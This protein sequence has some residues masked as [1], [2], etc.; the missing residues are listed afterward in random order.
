MMIQNNKDDDDDADDDGKHIRK[1]SVDFSTTS[2]Q[3]T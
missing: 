3:T 2:T 1:Q